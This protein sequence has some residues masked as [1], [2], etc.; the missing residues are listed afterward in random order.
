[1]I[2]NTDNRIAKKTVYALTGYNTDRS[3]ASV[4]RSVG[5][6]RLAAPQR[7]FLPAFLF[8]FLHIHTFYHIARKMRCTKYE[9]KIPWSGAYLLFNIYAVCPTHIHSIG[10]GLKPRASPYGRISLFHP[11]SKREKRIIL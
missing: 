1:M 4:S 3:R 8:L 2:F 11:S 7:G 10:G 6:S 5:Y 9:K